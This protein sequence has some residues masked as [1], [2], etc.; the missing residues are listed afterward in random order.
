MNVAIALEPTIC[1]IFVFIADNP[2][3]MRA[4]QLLVGGEKGGQ[5][6]CC[7]TAKFITLCTSKLL[8]SISNREGRPWEEVTGT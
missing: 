4:R 6:R 3:Q 7:H 8:H 5:I 2:N 1:S